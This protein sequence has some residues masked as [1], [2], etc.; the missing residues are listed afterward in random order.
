MPSKFVG[1]DSPTG[2]NSERDRRLTGVPGAFFTQLLP[3][4]SNPNELKT[5]LYFMFLA[6]QKRGE[7]KW[8]GYWELA[9]ST[10]L[11]AGLRKGGDPRP[12]IEHLR[13]AL[14][15]CMARGSLLRVEAA[16]P[17]PEFFGNGPVKGDL[18]PV[19]VTWFLLNT[20]GNREFLAGLEKGEIQIEDT[21]LLVG[22]ELWD[23][24]LPDAAASGENPRNSAALSEI[25]KW[26]KQ[27]QWRVR[28]S[29]PDIYTLY[30]QN[31]GALTPIL[32]ERLREAENLY[33]AAW[34]EEAFA[35]AVN[36][37]RR[38]WA[39]IIRILENWV[40]NGRERNQISERPAERPAER[41]RPKPGQGNS[42][43][44]RARG[45]GRTGLAGDGTSAPGTTTPGPAN[46]TPGGSSAP[47]N[48]RGP[49][50]FTKYTTGKYAHLTEP[51][52]QD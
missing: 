19:T 25:K 44:Q 52:S 13:E 34:I 2:P 36:Y 16:P 51:G 48:R 39:Y 22:I 6:G 33:P 20:A 26:N 50:D 18:E 41:S 49:I 8:V 15:L 47:S 37:N 21:N 45:N 11:L 30:E 27:R 1:F 9:E 43:A 31:I 4:I 24:P 40:T 32:S 28:S 46:G 7:P 10:E 38:S 23:K 35:E 29:R 3:Q 17:P 5:L 12:A 14:E 42:P